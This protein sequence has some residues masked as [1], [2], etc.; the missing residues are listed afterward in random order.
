[1]GLEPLNELPEEW[2]PEGVEVVP[3]HV[4]R[5]AYKLDGEGH[6]KVLLRWGAQLDEVGEEIG[7]RVGMDGEVVVVVGPGTELPGN[8]FASLARHVLLLRS[9]AVDGVEVELR[10]ELFGEALV[11]L[12]AFLYWEDPLLGDHEEG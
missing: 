9:V 1:M 5:V 3:L 4:L 12:H 8:V 11:E 2:Q 7:E 6:Y 10:D